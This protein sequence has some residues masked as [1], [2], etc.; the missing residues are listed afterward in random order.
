VEGCT[1]ALD[2]GAIDADEVAAAAAV[3]NDDADDVD[4]DV[5]ENGTPS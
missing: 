1:N 3:V 2:G 5:A 4:V